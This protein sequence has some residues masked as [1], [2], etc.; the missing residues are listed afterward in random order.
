M[1]YYNQSLRMLTDTFRGYMADMKNYLQVNDHARK[2]NK[3]L[4]VISQTQRPSI[5]DFNVDLGND[6]DWMQYLYV[7]SNNT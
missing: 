6:N 4:S 1:N 7:I 2:K 3:R 5:S